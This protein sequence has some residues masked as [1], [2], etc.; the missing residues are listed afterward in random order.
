MMLYLLE[1][2]ERQKGKNV[3]TKALLGRRQALIALAAEQNE[4]K[5][6]TFIAP[7]QD[8]HCLYTSLYGV[9]YLFFYHRNWT[10]IRTNFLCCSSRLY[11]QHLEYVLYS[12]FMKQ[13]C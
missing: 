7:S 11:S 5:I 10:S 6:R 8:L 2:A 1:D 13:F 4:S 3:S 12:L 9:I